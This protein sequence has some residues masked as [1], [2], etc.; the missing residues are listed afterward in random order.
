M[1]PT[2]KTHS[3]FNSSKFFSL[4]FVF[5]LFPPLPPPPPPP[6]SLSLSLSLHSVSNT[7]HVLLSQLLDELWRV[8]SEQKR[9]SEDVC[10]LC[11]QSA[12]PHPL[13]T[14]VGAVHLQRPPRT[15]GVGGDVM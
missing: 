7:F 11:V 13:R 14:Q 10:E 1:I 9:P 8:Q 2:N 6:S 3:F 12:D 15:A 5:L 4:L